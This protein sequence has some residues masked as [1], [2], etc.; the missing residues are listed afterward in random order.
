MATSK[1]IAALK[2]SKALA[3]LVVNEKVQDEY[4]STNCMPVNL[5]LSGKIKGR[6]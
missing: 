3:E 6:Y 4:V 1:L 2:K 5:L